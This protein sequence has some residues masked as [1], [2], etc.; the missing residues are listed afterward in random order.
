MMDGAVHRWKRDQELAD[1][2]AA[3]ICSILTSSEKHK[4]PPKE[5]MIDYDAKPEKKEPKRQ[6]PEQMAAI[7]KSLTLQCGGEVI[8]G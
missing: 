3:R 1:L 4:H 6:T 5:F 2:R 8:D 7:L